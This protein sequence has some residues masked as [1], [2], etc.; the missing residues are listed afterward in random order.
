MVSA[1]LGKPVLDRTVVLGE[2]SVHGMLLKVSARP[3]RMHAGRRRSRREAHPDP[4]RE[5]ARSRRVPDAILTSIAAVT[6]ASGLVVA[7]R[8]R[9]TLR[10][11]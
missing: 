4:E 3:E 11:G 8:M 2:M 6:F 7:V 9:E 10:R 5:Q 1:L